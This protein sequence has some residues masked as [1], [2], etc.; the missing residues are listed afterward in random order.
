V[1]IAVYLGFWDG[2]E[3]L[4]EQGASIFDCLYWAAE[5]GSRKAVKLI[6]TKAESLGSQGV[7]RNVARLPL[8]RAIQTRDSKLVKLSSNVVP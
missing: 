7:L 6:I 8:G 3:F 1:R 5:L 2:I 4:I